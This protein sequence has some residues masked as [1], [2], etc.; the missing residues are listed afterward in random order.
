MITARPLC[1][2]SS[3]ARVRLPQALLPALKRELRG[4]DRSAVERYNR[5][6]KRREAL[7]ASWRWLTNKCSEPRRARTG[8]QTLDNCLQ[9]IIW[10]R[11]MLISSPER[12]GTTRLLA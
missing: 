12:P 11:N 9:S 4:G 5:A 10:T 1:L 8:S 3:P 6:I 2:A 7:R